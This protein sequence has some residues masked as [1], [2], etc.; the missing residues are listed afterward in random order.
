L[1]PSVRGRG[2]GK[3]KLYFITSAKNE[4][5]PEF[6]GGLKGTRKKKDER[7]HRRREKEEGDGGGIKR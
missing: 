2:A 3:R 6:P 4:A 1:R 5:L 7:H